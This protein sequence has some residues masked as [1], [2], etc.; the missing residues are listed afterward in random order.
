MTV[1]DLPIMGAFTVY[2]AET[3][4]E[5]F[6][7]DGESWGDCPPDVADLEIGTIYA[8]GGRIMISAL[9]AEEDD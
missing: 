6:T 2:D 9:P 5:L 1:S 3:L 7:F 8:E 4:E